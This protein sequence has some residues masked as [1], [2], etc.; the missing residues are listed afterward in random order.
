MCQPP[1]NRLEVLLSM[2]SDAIE[3]ATDNGNRRYAAEQVCKAIAWLAEANQILA[4]LP[5]LQ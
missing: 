3:R 5:M 2:A 1:E 4:K